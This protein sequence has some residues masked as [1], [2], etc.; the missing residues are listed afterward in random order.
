[1]TV[2][3]GRLVQLR[4]LRLEALVSFFTIVVVTVSTGTAAASGT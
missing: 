1:M 4:L 3:A 2:V